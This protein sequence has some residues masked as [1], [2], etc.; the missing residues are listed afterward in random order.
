MRT[1]QPSDI[2]ICLSKLGLDYI[3]TLAAA[4]RLCEAPT[5]QDLMALHKQVHKPTLRDAAHEA[6]L[7]KLQALYWDVS[8]DAHLFT[9]QSRSEVPWERQES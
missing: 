2:A 8:L 3:D 6:L 1:L 9:I 4:S 7:E 5:K